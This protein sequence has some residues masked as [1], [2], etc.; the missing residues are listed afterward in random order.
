MKNSLTKEGTAFIITY[1]NSKS[2][3]LRGILT[4]KFK[5]NYT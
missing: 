1:K 3:V 2:Y 4:K 5:E